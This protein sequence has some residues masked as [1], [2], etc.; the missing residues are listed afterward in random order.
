MIVMAT[1]PP[2]NSTAANV[3]KSLTA[4]I[5]KTIKPTNTTTTAPNVLLR[6]LS[7]A[8]TASAASGT[9]QLNTAR[10]PWKMLV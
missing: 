7:L 2:A 5:C 4:L 6:S 8:S 3:R 1:T 10:L 9:S